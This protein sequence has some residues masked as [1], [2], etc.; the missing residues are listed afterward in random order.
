MADSRSVF[1]FFFIGIDEKD[2]FNTLLCSV[3]HNKLIDNTLLQFHWAGR[4]SRGVA[5]FNGSA[6]DE[7][8]KSISFVNEI[9]KNKAK[10]FIQ[11]LLDR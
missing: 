6:I 4:S 7:M 10:D 2:I 1:M 8:L 11:R 5:Q 3:Y 9:D